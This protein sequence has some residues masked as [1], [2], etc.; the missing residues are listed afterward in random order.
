MLLGRAS[1]GCGH[2][3]EKKS[4]Q[5][6]V[7]NRRTGDAYRINESGA[8]QITCQQRRANIALPNDAAI[9][10]VK[11]VDI[12]RFGHGND[13]RPAARA[14]IDVKWLRVNGAK[15]CAVKVQVACKIGGGC[16]RECR[17]NVKTVPR[18]I[19]VKLGDIHLRS[20][21]KSYAPQGCSNNR[22]NWK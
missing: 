8:W 5:A 9:D 18:R 4:A 14:A 1:V 20:C 15:D 13:R 3:I 6:E 11:C 16:R 7:D 12:I 21:G 2:C 10:R 22:R 17:I 19:V